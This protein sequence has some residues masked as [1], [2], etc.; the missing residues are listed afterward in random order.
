[1]IDQF[2]QEIGLV[3]KL[4]NQILRP[5]YLQWDNGICFSVGSAV[6][7]P[8]KTPRDKDGSTESVKGL[9]IVLMVKKHN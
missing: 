3:L 7:L 4:G 5:P 8:K 9:W 2:F 1:M 6:A